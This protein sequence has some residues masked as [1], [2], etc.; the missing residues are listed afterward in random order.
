MLWAGL[1]P[2]SWIPSDFFPVSLKS[3]E[4]KSFVLASSCCSHTL[5]DISTDLP[6][7]TIY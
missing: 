7:V 5:Q 4:F 3:Y 2:R 6:C 1:L